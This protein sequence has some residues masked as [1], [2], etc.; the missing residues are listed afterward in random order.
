MYKV[1]K[2]SINGFE[3]GHWYVYRGH[4]RG[5][6]WNH[7]GLMDLVLD[8]KPHMCVSGQGRCARFLDERP[9]KRS[10]GWDWG[11]LEQWCEVEAPSKRS[12]AKQQSPGPQIDIKAIRRRLL[13]TGP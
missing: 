6:G 9:S 5:F 1:I 13:H 4:S 2:D 12:K 11:Y 3:E 7:E 8:N 10:G